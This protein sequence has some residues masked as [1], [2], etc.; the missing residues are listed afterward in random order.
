MELC[1]HSCRFF[2]SILAECSVSLIAKNT[3]FFLT[4]YKQIWSIEN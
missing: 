4:G 1:I 3:V 2:D